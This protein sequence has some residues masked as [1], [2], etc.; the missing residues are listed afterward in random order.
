[1]D[2]ALYD[3]FR[4]QGSIVAGLLALVAGVLAFK[5]AMR[6][7]EKQVAAL[8]TQTEALRQQNS[9]LKTERRR[10]PGA[11]GNHCHQASRKR[12]ADRER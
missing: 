9:D 4:D 11:R 2:S 5:G 3:F 6:A 12:L 7:A 10:R 1:M 8:N